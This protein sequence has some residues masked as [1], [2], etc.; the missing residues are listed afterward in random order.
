[1][2]LVRAALDYWFIEALV[3][4]LV[5]STALLAVPAIDRR[6]AAAA[7]RLPVRAGLLGLLTRYDVVGVRRRPRSTAPTCMFWLFAL[8]WAAFQ[9]PHVEAPAAG[10]GA[11]MVGTVPGFF[12]GQHRDGWTSIARPAP[13]IWLPRVRMPAVAAPA[14]GVLA[15]AS[16]CIYLVH[17]QIYP[18][19]EF[20]AAAGHA[21]LG[22]LARRRWWL[23]GERVRADWVRRDARGSALG[24]GISWRDPGAP[25]RS[26][27][28]APP[29]LVHPGEP[30][31]DGG[32]PRWAGSR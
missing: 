28:I 24:R 20:A 17:W 25:R 16:L 5:A 4:I 1:M 31:P 7:V 21:L 19:Y 12:D 22:L 29:V 14:V 32:R 2:E 18:A 3:W 23:V 30:A 10:L 15:A 9:A 8:G 26:N 6:V 27:E 11:V 13:L